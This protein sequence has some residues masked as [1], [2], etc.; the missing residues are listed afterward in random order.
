MARYLNEIVLNCNYYLKEHI[1]FD[2][3]G[4][5]SKYSPNFNGFLYK[6]KVVVKQAVGDGDVMPNSASLPQN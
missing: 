1:N 5:F 6:C 2:T 4:D 3:Y